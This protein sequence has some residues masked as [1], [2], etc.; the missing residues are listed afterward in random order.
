MRVKL[1]L[2]LRNMCRVHIEIIQK[3]STKMLYFIFWILKCK[4][5]IYWTLIECMLN[6]YKCDMMIDED[7]TMCDMI[8][9]KND[10]QLFVNIHRICFQYEFNAYINYVVINVLII[11]MSMNS[12]LI[13]VEYVLNFEKSKI[14][15]TITAC[16]SKK[17]ELLKNMYL[18]YIQ[19]T[20][21]LHK[22]MS[23]KNICLSKNDVMQIMLMNQ[24]T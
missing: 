24:N 6:V 2:F 13:Y 15:K 5:C 12:R 23:W 20:F 14:Q 16:R 11:R 3:F 18:I 4:F 1:S 17:N 19:Y 9:I 22:I 10:R 7:I 8:F 21:N